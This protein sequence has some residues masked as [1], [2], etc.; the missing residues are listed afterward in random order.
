[1]RWRTLEYHDIIG[2]GDFDASGFPGASAASYKLAAADFKAHL[3][4]IA[5]SSVAVA[6]AD[7]AIAGGHGVPVLF[8]FDDGGVGALDAASLLEEHGWRGHFLVAS[9]LIGTTGFLSAGQIADL[10]RRGHVIGSHSHSHPARFSSLTEARMRQEWSD[11]R[12]RLEQIVGQEVRIA[13]VPLGD[14]SPRALATAV[15]AGYQV[16]F[17]SEPVSRVREMQGCRIAGRFTLRRT[18]PASLAAAFAAGVR[19]P[20]WRQWC[21]WNARKLLKKA[22][23]G[24][25][26]AVRERLFERD[27]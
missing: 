19:G 4:A 11:S 25:Y 9:G 22:G 17:T 7:Q 15:A 2:A 24:A 21:G 6:R 26:L 1:M 13:S 5:A 10:A 14:L 18:S 27:A 8:T 20:A 16:L 23:G 12:Q 3:A